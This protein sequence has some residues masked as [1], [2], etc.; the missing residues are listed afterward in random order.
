MSHSQVV[1]VIKVEMLSVGVVVT[2]K[3]IS[4]TKGKGEFKALT[5]DHDLFPSECFLKPSLSFGQLS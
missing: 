4:I 3:E 2:E 5:S 1:H